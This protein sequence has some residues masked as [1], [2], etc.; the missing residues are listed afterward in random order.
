[1]WTV[2]NEH[3]TATVR[4]S[5]GE[6]VSLWHKQMRTE[7]LWQ[8]Q[9]A[10]W[11]H[12]ATQLFPVVGRL[13]HDGL[14]LDGQFWPLPAHGFLRE[15]T[16]YCVDQSPDRLTLEACS[17][18]QARK[19]WPRRWRVRLAF[20]L[21]ASG[22]TFQQTVINEDSRTL[23][24]SAGW[25]PGFALPVASRSGWWVEFSPAVSGPFF[26][27]NRT[28][29]TDG[30]QRYVTRFALAGTSFAAGA[31]Y[32]GDC[33]HRVIRVR[34][35]D[36]TL[37]L[38]LETGEQPWLALWGVPGADLLCIEPL[39]GT[40]DAPDADGQTVNKR[41]MQHL[42]AGESQTFTVRLRFAVDA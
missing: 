5:G 26:T 15:Q 25:H 22:L 23:P 33:Q 30:S 13:I 39:A 41:G 24:Y 38:T 12:T 28:L 6:L 37:A 21:E 16:F 42:P 11:N 17:T 27:D 35:P 7:R 2:E 18:P 31:V 40:T 19:Q 9:A 20:A 34:A 10:V 1:M 36:G 3:F 29:K 8:P 14:W 4:A 32:F